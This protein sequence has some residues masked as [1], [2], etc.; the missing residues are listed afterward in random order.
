M[1]AIYRKGSR[2]HAKFYLRTHAG[3]IEPWAQGT[4]IGE[5]DSLG[6]RLIEVSWDSG[7]RFYVL[8]SEIEMIAE[9][10]AKSNDNL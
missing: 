7:I 10:R 6:R 5:I 9:D 2:C 1:D 4:V 8:A 3:A